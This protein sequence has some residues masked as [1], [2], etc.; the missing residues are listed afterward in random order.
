MQKNLSN[1]IKISPNH[2]NYRWKRDIKNLW[3]CSKFQRKRMTIVMGFKIIQ[4]DTSKAIPI[5]RFINKINI[6]RR[7]KDVKILFACDFEDKNNVLKKCKRYNFDISFCEKNGE[8]VLNSLQENPVDVLVVDAL[9]DRVNVF[10][11]LLRFPMYL[12]PMKTPTVIVVSDI[13]ID[14]I[15]KSF[16]ECGAFSQMPSTFTPEELIAKIDDIESLKE[17]NR[18]WAEANNLTTLM[19]I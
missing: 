8:Y 17:A 15:Q 1:S 10:G 7:K 18:A 11:L 16:R 5:F 14:Y 13:E 9:T 3:I 12:D 2:L 19:V 4:N 6:F